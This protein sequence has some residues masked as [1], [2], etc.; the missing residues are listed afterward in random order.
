MAPRL[1]G[2]GLVL[3][4]SRRSISGY[5]GSQVGYDCCLSRCRRCSSH[6]TCQDYYP[7]SW[8][9]VVVI[10]EWWTTQ[11]ILPCLIPWFLGVAPEVTEVY[12][13]LITELCFKTMARSLKR[14][15]CR[16]GD[17]SKFNRDIRDIQECQRVVHDK[18]LLNA[19]RYWAH[20]HTQPPS[21][22]GVYD[23]LLDVMQEICSKT[24]EVSSIF[25][26]VQTAV[27][28]LRDALNWVKVCCS[29][30][31]LY[32]L[33]LRPSNR[34]LASQKRRHILPE[35]GR[36]RYG[37][38]Y[39][40]CPIVEY[41]HR[42]QRDQF[43]ESSSVFSVGLLLKIRSLHRS[44]IHG[45]HSCRIW[46]PNVGRELLRILVFL[47]QIFLSWYQILERFLTLSLR[48]SYYSPYQDKLSL[49][50]RSRLMTSFLSLIMTSYSYQPIA[51]IS[52]ISYHTI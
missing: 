1:G 2:G 24:L 35:R 19:C 27:L 22:G 32:F 45:L 6:P 18:L 16:I 44:C 13:R 47:I 49:I 34:S 8:S 50:L 28:M 39:S 7:H 36:H 42:R 51:D 46:D 17:P 52:L 48:Y 41:R 25:D 21:K 15:M 37:Q 29:F 33:C 40:R 4:W 30:H 12:H 20:H 26:H 43:W 38:Q 14:N 5:Y 9:G 10:G 31:L 23:S 3:P 11:P